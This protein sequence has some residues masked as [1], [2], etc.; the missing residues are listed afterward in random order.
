[1]SIIILI[2]A[3]GSGKG[4]QGD[5]LVKNFH[6]RKVSTGDLLRGHIKN[7]TAIGIKVESILSAGRL[8]SNEIL[9]QLVKQS[10][11]EHKESTVILD[12][13]PRTVEQAKSLT[14]IDTSK[15]LQ[16]VI[17][18]E[19][20]QKLLL[21]RLTGRRVCS[22]CGATYHIDGMMPQQTNTC[23]SCGGEIVTRPDDQE[24]K[25]LTRLQV[26]QDETSPV[27]AYYER[28]G[29]LKTVEGN[30]PPEDVKRK[31]VNVLKSLSLEA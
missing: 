25:I 14:E 2:G 30:V 11:D 22:S 24:D 16:A 6:Y 17:H 9:L 8:V 7:K 31:I 10:L 27:L 3:P 18:I 5:L 21:E 23:D 19:L 1:M 12:G 26:Y 29:L 20:D 15:R 28:L 4:T 13:Y